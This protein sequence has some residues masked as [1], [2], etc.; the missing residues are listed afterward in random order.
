[1]KNTQLYCYL[2]QL[3]IFVCWAFLAA[4][5][6]CYLSFIHASPLPGYRNFKAPAGI[7]ENQWSVVH[8]L[9]A[10]CP[11]SANLAVYLENRHPSLSAR[12]QVIIIGN[13][14]ALSAQ[15]EQAGW[16]VTSLS[17]SD[18]EAKFG[19]GGA[20][21]LLIY[22]SHEKLVY[23]GG[24]LGR[25]IHSPREP[26]QDLVM[27]TSLENGQSPK[28]LAAFGCFITQKLRHQMDPLGLK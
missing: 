5:L 25:P 28:P 27:L 14:P 21:W 8:L 26:F 12:E 23:S 11:C 3:G 16:K 6:I 9:A 15:L 4:G 18:A 7:A 13:N 20:P 19:P 1:M 22:D 17:E 2:I 24:Y 10:D